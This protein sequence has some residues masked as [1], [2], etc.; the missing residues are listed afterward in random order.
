MKNQQNLK[1]ATITMILTGIMLLS[2]SLSGFTLSVSEPG[3]ITST[4]IGSD[5]ISLQTMPDIPELE[6]HSKYFESQTLNSRGPGLLYILVDPVLYP[7]ISSE[8]AR[9]MVDVTNDGYNP[10]LYT[11]G[12]ANETEVKALLQSGY[13]SGM[14]GSLFVGDIPIAW[15]EMQDWFDGEDYG[16]TEFPIDLYYMDLDGTWIDS[17]INGKYDGHEAGAGTLE[18]EIWIGRLYASTVTIS[19]ENEVSLV[20]NYFDKNHEYRMGNTSLY[21]RAMVYVDDDWI[22]WAGEYA[23]DVGVRYNDFTLIDAAETTRVDDYKDRMDNNYDWM[24]LFAHSYQGGHGF[25]YNG[26]SQ[27]EWMYNPELDTVDSNSHFYNLFCCSAGDYSYSAANGYITGH[28]VFSENYGICAI[29]SAKTGSMLNFAD[30][31]TPLDNGE[32][33]GDAFLQW[34]QLNGETGAGVDSRC[35]FYGMTTIGDPTL[36]TQDLV[37]P[38]SPSEQIISPLGDDIV[39]DWL[40]SPSPDIHHYLIYRASD[41]SAF[42]F[43]NPWHNTSIDANPL[44]CYWTDIGAGSGDYFYVIRAV[45]YAMNEDQNTVIIGIYHITLETSEW[46]LVSLPLPQLYSNVGDVLYY[47][48]WDC[49]RWYDSQDKQDPWKTFNT[50]NPPSINDLDVLNR[51]MGI[52]LKASSSDELV[53]TGYAPEPTSINLKA[54]WNLVGYPTLTSRLASDALAGTDA[55]MISICNGTAPGLIDDRADLS[56]VTMHPGEGYWV[57]VPFDTVWTVDW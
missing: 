40:P 31:Y 10:Q 56:T 19:G 24:S 41:P 21:N 35:W 52:W 8:I 43:N 11:D 2:F 28:Y 16:W 3:T 36:K 30:F 23:D 14:V 22:P 42:D 25:Y 17:D 34:F 47:A 46:N 45:D 53:V 29:A 20:Q 54:G 1:R 49:A 15:Y 32:C 57:H 4:P 6:D 12:W 38:E 44:D 39:L 51:T 27:F 18:P 9:Y 7:S 37:K 33:I 55:D 50:M 5:K 13:S 26:G 48:E